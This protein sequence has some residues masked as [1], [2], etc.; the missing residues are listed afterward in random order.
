[1]KTLNIIEENFY[2]LQITSFQKVITNI[3]VL[4]CMYAW[5]YMNTKSAINQIKVIASYLERQYM[6]IKI[7][8]VFI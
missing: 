3:S 1:M 5:G 6:S 4:V 7:L 2:S 8:V